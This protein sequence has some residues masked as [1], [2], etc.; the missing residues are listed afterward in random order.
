MSDNEGL[1]TKKDAARRLGVSYGLLQK[2][3]NLNQV[4]TVSLGSVQR[5]KADSINQ[6]VTAEEGTWVPF[7]QT[8]ATD[9]LSAR[10]GRLEESVRHCET[11]LTEM[12]VNS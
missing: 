8:L 4:E 7:S 9:E 2:M 1:L 10:V 3:I 5:V 6:M 11:L 12:T